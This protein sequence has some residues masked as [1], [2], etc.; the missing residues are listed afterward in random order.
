M[1]LVFR[2]ANGTYPAKLDP[3]TSLPG[4]T[5]AK[6]QDL[7]FEQ[8]MTYAFR[9]GLLFYRQE[10]ASKI[11][12]SANWKNWNYK[13]RHFA[14]DQ[15]PS[16]SNCR[17]TAYCPMQGVSSSKQHG[18]CCFVIWS[19][20]RL[21][22]FVHEV[23]IFHCITPSESWYSESSCSMNVWSVFT[24]ILAHLHSRCLYV[25]LRSG[26]VLIWL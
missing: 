22:Y 3:S 17:G 8:A 18:N 6:N 5:A 1:G 4:E 26:L 2:E 12:A 19:Q 11:S 15:G 20:T 7:F 16:G 14:I 9:K 23:L 25:T 10:L 21:V 24:D 13:T